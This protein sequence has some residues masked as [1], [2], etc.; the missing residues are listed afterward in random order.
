MQNSPSDPAGLLKPLNMFLLLDTSGSMSGATGI[1]RTKIE[2][3]KEAVANYIDMFNPFKDRIALID[4]G[5]TVKT[6]GALQFFNSASGPHLDLKNQVQLLQA[7]GQT[8]PCDALVRSIDAAAT[9][10][11]DPNRATAVVLFT[12]GSPNVSRLKYCDF[13]ENEECQAP[14]RIDEALQLSSADSEEGW[15]SWITKWGRRR[16]ASCPNGVSTDP[17]Q[18]AMFCDPVYG[19]P[20]LRYGGGPLAGQL[21]PLATI[22]ANL[23]LHENGIFVWKNGPNPTDE[24][25]ITT[26]HPTLPNGPYILQFETLTRVEDNYLWNGPSYLVHASTP[27]DSGRSL[28]DRIPPTTT[29][30]PVTCG[31][32]SRPSYPGSLDPT[33]PTDPRE[34]YT[35]SRYFGSRILNLNWSLDAANGV[36]D[37]HRHQRTKVG[38]D[39]VDSNGP[40]DPPVYFTER[41]QQR[42][43]N[44]QQQSPGC[45]TTLNTQIPFTQNSADPANIF[46]GARTH[47]DHRFLSNINDSTIKQVGEV[48]KS[49]E[50][51]YYCALRAADH[52]RHRFG[53]IV[54]VVGLGPRA[55]DIYGEQCEDP[56]QNPLDFDSRKDHFLRRLAFAPESL[57]RSQVDDFIDGQNASWDSSN[58]FGFAPRTLTNCQNHPLAGVALQLGYGERLTDGTP[59]SLDPLG[60]RFT[61][62]HLGAY[63]GCNDS[64]QLN[65]VFGNIAKQILLRLAT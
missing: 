35:H 28:L 30:A 65:E 2:V 46:V 57:N 48:V 55:A 20:E 51:P 58:N 61:P 29:P 31:A 47:Q 10:Q 64:S 22:Q 53:A 42:L 19:W 60:H 59:F 45:L 14:E 25:P 11:L 9:A 1:G 56:L 38:L 6:E 21:I 17:S 39:A 63:Y 52:L 43:K 3:L 40:I 8:N 5:T 44:N 36:P 15:Y 16:L 62:R 41:N 12:D 37:Q 18:A 32:G 54:F 26:E 33:S 27:P 49:A 50:L 23:R 34:M 13:D 7:S 4:Y 24:L